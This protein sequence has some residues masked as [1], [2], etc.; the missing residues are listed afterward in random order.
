MSFPTDGRPD[1]TRRDAVS[2]ILQ[3]ALLAHPLGS[4]LLMMAVPSLTRGD[5]HTDLQPLMAEVRRLVEAMEYLGEPFAEADRA[6]LDAAANMGDEA[7]AVAEIQRVLDPK[8]LLVVRINP[9]SRVSTERGAAPARLVEHGWRAFLMKVRNEAGVTGALDA[10]SPAGEA[11]VSSRHSDCDRAAL[12]PAGRCR[13]PLARPRDVRWQA[14]GAEALRSGSRVPDRAG[15]QPRPRPSRSAARRDARRRHSGHRIPQP[16]GGAVRRRAVARCRRCAC[17]TRHGRPTTAAFVVKD[18]IGRV[19]P[20]RSKRLAP[21]FFFQEQIYRANGE[22]VRLPAGEFSV[23]VRP[24]AGVPARD[25]Q[26]ERRRSE[27]A[28]PT[29]RCGAGST[30]RRSAGTPAIITSMRPGAATTRARPRACGPRT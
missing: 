6:R 5:A 8:C 7:R 21:D 11:S 1:V 12:R 24:R 2:S 13:G 22:S 15:V 3:A 20:A 4:R 30:R 18:G 14:D 19:Y 9:E 29:S 25:T 23:T 16:R 28:S 17:T 26:R 10:E 27:R